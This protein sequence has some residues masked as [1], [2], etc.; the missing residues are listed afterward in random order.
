[1]PDNLLVQSDTLNFYHQQVQES[2]RNALVYAWKA[3]GILSQVRSS[4]PHGE[5]T[6]WLS[7]NFQGTPQTARGYMRISDRWDEIES[8]LDANP[9]LSLRRGLKILSSPNTAPSTDPRDV[10]EE[11]FAHAV[12]LTQS[13]HLRSTIYCAGKYVY[14][15][16]QDSTILLR[17][18]APE[19]FPEPVAFYA[20]DYDSPEF[21]VKNGRV[22]FVKRIQDSAYIWTRTKTAGV[23][24]EEI[25]EIINTFNSHYH[26]S[27]PCV[28]FTSNSD[29]WTGT[30]TI[31]N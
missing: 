29:Y 14:I 5:W 9:N 8:A 21:Y 18:L 22:H 11:I 19:P 27:G 30:F 10:L 15:M 25:E 6:P 28:E 13:G 3:G 16:N 23:P 31:L 2:L 26:E 24:P 7:A 12:A 17:F 4:L 20:N 1:M